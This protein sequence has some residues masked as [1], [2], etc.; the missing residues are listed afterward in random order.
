[1]GLQ[2]QRVTGSKCSMKPS[3]KRFATVIKG[4]PP[5]GNTDTLPE[6]LLLERDG[7]IEIYYSGF[8]YIN[9]KAKIVLVGITPGRVQAVNALRAAQYQ[10]KQ[11]A[12]LDVALKAAKSTGSFSG[13]M[14]NNLVGM[15]DHFGLH[16]WL[17]LKS[18]AALFGEKSD[19]VQSDSLLRYPVFVRGGNYNGQPSM[20]NHPLLQRYLLEHFA[21]SV[22]LFPDA[23]FIPLGDQVGGVFRWLM[24]RQILDDARVLD[25][26]QHPSGAN[27]E[28]IAYLL[29]RKSRKALSAKTNPDKIDTAR[30]R[31]RH[32]IKR[33]KPIARL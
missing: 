27:A 9:P 1:M 25:G 33:L 26:F 7:D 19:L 18:C 2:L 23:L 22:R 15:L 24:E 30:D 32:K 13:P 28:R 21:A 17:G 8:D 3:L 31:L 10:L 12:T 4:L 14:R 16:S 5:F 6:Q 20:V 29:E 11:G